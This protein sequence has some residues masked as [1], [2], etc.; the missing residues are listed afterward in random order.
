M[1]E[2]TR[3]VLMVQ[4]KVSLKK[5]EDE[6]DSLYEDSVVDGDFIDTEQHKLYV[7]LEEIESE[8]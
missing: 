2:N 6:I 7:Y 5:I 3:S 4:R 8:E 1:M